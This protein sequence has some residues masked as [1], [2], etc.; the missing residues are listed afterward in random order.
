MT[1]ADDGSKTYEYTA[2]Y[3]SQP[4]SSPLGLHRQSQLIEPR[5]LSMMTTRG[6]ADPA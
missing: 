2:L 1:R 5:Y 3:L 6:L 4:I